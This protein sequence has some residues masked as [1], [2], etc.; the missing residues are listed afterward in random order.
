MVRTS[1]IYN[2]K[3]D[4][5]TAVCAEFGL[6]ALNTVREMR[7]ALGVLAGSTNPID[8]SGYRAISPRRAIQELTLSSSAMD[9]VRK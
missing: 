3:K 8:D 5:L 7:K 9:R 6:E 2:F 1:R 4:E